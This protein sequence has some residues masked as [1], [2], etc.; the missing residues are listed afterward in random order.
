[1]GVILQTFYENCPALEN[2]EGNWWNYLKELIPSIGKA[3]FTALWLPPPGKAFGYKSMGYDVFDYFDLGEFNQK[4]NISTWFG[5]K[6]QLIELI[7]VIHSN[8]MSAYADL[9][10]NHN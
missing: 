4:G 8:K 1:M 7:S 9:V 3:G 5:T 10:L 6:E 2:Q